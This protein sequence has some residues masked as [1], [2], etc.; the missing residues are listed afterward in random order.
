MVEALKSATPSSCKTPATFIDPILPNNQPGE[1][2]EFRN[3]IQ[4]P[5]NRVVLRGTAFAYVHRT[6]GWER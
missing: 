5:T 2:E 4:L 3:E 6:Q 1:K